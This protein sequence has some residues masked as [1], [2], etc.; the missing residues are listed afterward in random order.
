M[1]EAAR[2]ATDADVPRLA[3]L[4][5]AGVAELR[6]LRGGDV[7][8]ARGARAEPVE[9]KLRAT[10]ADPDQLV[11]AGTLDGVVLGY[12]V[13]R[14]ESLQDGRTLG[15]VDDIFV[16]EGARAVGLGEALMDRVVAWCAERGCFGIDA[17]ALPGARDTKNFFETFGFTARLL[18]VHRSLDA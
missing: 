12:A 15:V 14:T 1:D 2:A 8:A 18:V 17:V 16:E 6:P 3:E 5:R 10:V 13:A 4:V 9:D 11:L 7:W